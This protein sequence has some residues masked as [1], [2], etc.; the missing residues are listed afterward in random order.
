MIGNGVDLSKYLVNFNSADW[1]NQANAHLQ[2]A[3]NQALPYGEKY[4]QQAVNAV[5]DY[6]NQAQKNIAQGYQTAQA[7]NTPQHLATYNA[8]DAYTNSLGLP[9]PQ[10]GSYNLAQNMNAQATGTTPSQ[11]QING[12]PPSVQPL[13]PGISQAP[14]SSTPLGPN[15]GVPSLFT[16]VVNGQNVDRYGIPVKNAYGPQGMLQ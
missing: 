16:H 10:G 13:P 6:S 11:Q 9:S 5:Q 15:G 7:L 8:L 2:Q 14:G 1:A 12:Q 3:I 4:T